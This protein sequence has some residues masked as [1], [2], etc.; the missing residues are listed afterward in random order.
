MNIMIIMTV[1]LVPGQQLEPTLSLSRAGYSS[2]ADY[3]YSIGNHKPIIAT[4]RKGRIGRAL[5]RWGG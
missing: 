1:I 2:A 4:F 3:P 5:L